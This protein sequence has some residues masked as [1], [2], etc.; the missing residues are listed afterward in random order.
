MSKKKSRWDFI[1][2][3]FR[4]KDEI[5]KG[6]DFCDS[7]GRI[8]PQDELHH[9]LMGSGIEWILCEECTDRPPSTWSKKYGSHRTT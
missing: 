9:V 8:Y 4:S 2:E 6:M 7:C 1:G 5:P 3:F